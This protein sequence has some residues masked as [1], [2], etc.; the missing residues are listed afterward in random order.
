MLAKLLTQPLLCHWLGLPPWLALSPCRPHVA[1]APPSRLRDQ[2]CLSSSS[3]RILKRDQREPSHSVCTSCP[4]LFASEWLRTLS[5]P[6]SRLHLAICPALRRSAPLLV[7]VIPY[8]TYRTSHQALPGLESE[9]SPL[10]LART[11]V[12]LVL[13]SA[14]AASDSGSEEASAEALAAWCL[15]RLQVELGSRIGWCGQLE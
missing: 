5:F 11:R 4:I 9:S 1:A 6:L 14:T 3:L 15:L 7:C 13:A 10:L 12:L 2:L 8:I